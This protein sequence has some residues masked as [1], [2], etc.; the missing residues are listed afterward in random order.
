MVI[1]G[2]KGKDGEMVPL[3]EVM[4]FRAT[5]EQQ[6]LIEHAAEVS[7]KKPAEFVRES[8]LAAAEDVIGSQHAYRVSDE[9]WN[10]FL[11]EVESR[12]GVNANFVDF[13]K[14]PKVTE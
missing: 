8:T 6:K 1:G 9:K 5:V 3:K 14:K 10:A 4:S 2:R 11:D 13:L 12:G 7:G